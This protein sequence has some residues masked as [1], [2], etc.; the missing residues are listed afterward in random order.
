MARTFVKNINNKLLLDVF[1]SLLNAIQVSLVDLS[2]REKIAKLQNMMVLDPVSILSIEV[3]MLHIFD[4]LGEYTHDDELIQENIRNSISNCKG[5]WQDTLRKISSVFWYGYSWSQV[6]VEDLP[7]GSKILKEIYT[8]NPKNYGF[9]IRNG[10][11]IKIVYL[12]YMRSVVEL[13]YNTG[14]HLVTGSDKNFDYYLGTGRAEA[15]LPYWE[16]HKLIMP[17]LAVACHVRQHQ[18]WLSKQKPVRM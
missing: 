1:D 8:L 6:A 13:A 14:I 17:V 9:Y 12:N 5:T 18:Y 7:D 16:L 4:I 2:R 10:K 3:T 11:I 15:A